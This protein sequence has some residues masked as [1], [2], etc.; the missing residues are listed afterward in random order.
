MTDMAMTLRLSDDEQAVLQALAEREGVTEHEVIRRALLERAE[1]AR[2][3]DVV[4]AS[5]SRAVARY[6]DLLDRLSR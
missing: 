6:A 2:A 1:G 4:Q 3:L 5:G